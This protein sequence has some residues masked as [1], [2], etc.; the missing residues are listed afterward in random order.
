MKQ[1]KSALFNSTPTATV[2]GPEDAGD[3]TYIGQIVGYDADDDPLSY[4]RNV[5]PTH[6]TI[7]VD[8]SGNYTYTPDA[9]I[10][11]T[12]GTD[13]FTI[14]VIESNAGTHIHGFGELLARAFYPYE[15]FPNPAS[16]SRALQK[17]TV[18]ISAPS[19]DSSGSL[20][21][22]VSLPEA[23]DPTTFV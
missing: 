17:V 13:S 11:A 20:T 19:D 22:T 9:D 18:T 5:N 16:Y 2:T 3:G 10:L 14:E 15:G 6:G 23:S 7:T 1:L 21:V 4:T 12:G 8:A